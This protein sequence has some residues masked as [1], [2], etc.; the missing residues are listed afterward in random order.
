MHC[1]LRQNFLV[2]ATARMSM[3]VLAQDPMNETDFAHDIDC[4]SAQGPQ[5]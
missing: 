3:F 5:A 2:I 4:I 1:C